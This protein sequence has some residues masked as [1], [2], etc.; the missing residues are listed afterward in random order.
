MGTRKVARRET[1]RGDLREKRQK[2]EAEWETCEKGMAGCHSGE[3]DV[4]TKSH[5]EGL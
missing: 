5:G 4:A 2:R 3:S 1:E